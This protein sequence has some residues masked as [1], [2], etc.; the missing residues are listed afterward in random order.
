MEKWVIK[1]NLEASVRVWLQ[2]IQNLR[3]FFFKF[4]M[5]CQDRSNPN[6]G[7]IKFPHLPFLCHVAVSEQAPPPS[8]F[9]PSA[10]LCPF[11]LNFLHGTA[12]KLL[13]PALLCPA[14]V[15]STNFEPLSKIFI[16]GPFKFLKKL[17]KKI[18][19]LLKTQY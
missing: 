12:A 2:K 5:A 16:N 8:S 13:S 4:E 9:F 19:I 10:F 7:P 18:I 15:G 1:R 3:A 6:R 14:R 17:I 11:Y